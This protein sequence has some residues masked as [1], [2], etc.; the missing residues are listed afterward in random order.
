[1]PD[2]GKAWL[3]SGVPSG[4]ANRERLWWVATASQDGVAGLVPLS[5]C[6]DGSALVFATPERSVTGRNL[7]ASG[8]ARVGLGPT[9]DVVMIVGR[10]EVFS[11]AEVSDEIGDAFAAAHWDARKETKPYAYYRVVPERI[12]AWREENEIKGRDLMID[13]AWLV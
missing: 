5:Y 10:V 2:S 6:W 11:A 9:R 4:T 3:T 1:M 12:Q 7:A 13:G 8:R